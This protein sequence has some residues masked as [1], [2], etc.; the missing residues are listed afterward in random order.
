MGLRLLLFALLGS[1]LMAGLTT[2]VKSGRADFWWALV[3]RI[4]EGSESSQAIAEMKLAL[5]DHS[6]AV[7][8]TSNYRLLNLD[9]E[10][11]EWVQGELSAGLS[12]DPL[13]QVAQRIQQHW[14]RYTG[15]NIATATAPTL[16]GLKNHLLENLE[17]QQPEM[18]HMACVVSPVAGG[19]SHRALL[20]T[21]QRLQDFQP[22]LLHRTDEVTFF[23]TCPHCKTKH[24][25]RADR[26]KES[27]SLECPTC[28]L[29]YA[30]VASDTRG[31]FHYA[32]EFLTGYQPPA[33]YPRGQSRIE[34]LFTIWSAVHHNCTYTPD[35][36]ENLKKTDRWQTALETQV[37]GKGDCEDSAIYLADWLLA[38]GYDARVALGR[39]GD[40]G[41]HA[42]C[43]VRLDE[44]EYLLETT[45]EGNPD[46]D[47]P[48][49]ISRVG[50]RYIPEI[51]FD[52]WSLYVRSSQR[53]PWNGNYWDEKNWIRLE[54][55]GKEPLSTTTRSQASRSHLS[56]VHS[57]KNRLLDPSDVA[58]L[59]AQATQSSPFLR[60]R[61]INY[62]GNNWQ[63]PPPVGHWPNSVD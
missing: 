63:T 11:E 15:I 5:L 20:I 48:P 26:Q 45:S 6:N 33:I 22:E 42:W 16:D 55:R 7:R 36:V 28:Q 24:I 13:S 14:P 50:S 4:G 9:T 59:R 2:L 27:F 8:S 51:L 40:I 37:R 62:G 39:Y 52:R 3:K 17:S 41:G 32:N 23:N 34:Q 58:F 29:T 53:Q 25:S 44:V 18:T 61:N 12:V 56:Q 30:L 60:L 49:L 57:I 43:V 1:A 54:P 47:S 31:R 21:G 10:L 46:F 19:I 35:P 38:R